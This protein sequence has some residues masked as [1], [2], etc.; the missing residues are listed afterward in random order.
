MTKRVLV[1]VPGAGFRVPPLDQ[2]AH[3]WDET[4]RLIDFLRYRKPNHHSDIMQVTNAPAGREG[5][6]GARGLGQRRASE[7]ACPDETPRTHL[8]RPDA[9]AAAFQRRFFGKRRSLL[10]AKVVP[11]CSASWCAY[12]RTCIGFFA[13]HVPPGPCPTWCTS[14]PHLI[15]CLY[16]VARPPAAHK[17]RGS[18]SPVGRRRLLQGCEHQQPVLRPYGSGDVHG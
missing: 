8:R 10:E 1:V 11:S 5:P 13:S 7:H 4:L 18:D 15:H 9:E 6:G 3:F 17:A 16:A 12:A 14:H 2:S